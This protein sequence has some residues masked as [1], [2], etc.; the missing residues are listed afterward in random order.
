MAIID[1]IAVAKANTKAR[2]PVTNSIR[3]VTKLT[4]AS[5]ND[6]P[7]WKEN[8]IYPNAATIITRDKPVLMFGSIEAPSSVNI[9]AKKRPI[10]EL[11]TKYFM[12][13]FTYSMLSYFL[14]V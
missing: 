12:L 9:H 3:I 8:P 2:I 13:F 4:F 11:T 14:E 7:A 1:P 6:I 10:N 5:I